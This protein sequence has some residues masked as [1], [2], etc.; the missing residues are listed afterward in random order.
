MGR[1]VDR[2]NIIIVKLVDGV[3]IVTAKYGSIKKCMYYYGIDC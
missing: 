3:N 1:I 2:V